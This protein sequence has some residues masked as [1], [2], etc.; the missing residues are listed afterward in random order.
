MA[1]C[2]KCNA[3]IPD[4]RI[5]CNK[6]MKEIETPYDEDYLDRLLNQGEQAGSDT[7]QQESHVRE[8]SDERLDL[9]LEANMQE[10]KAKDSNEESLDNAFDFLISGSTLE[11]NN[12]Q[13]EA[14]EAVEEG[15]KKDSEDVDDI[16]ILEQIIDN[17][18]YEEEDKEPKEFSYDSLIDEVL[19][20]DTPVVTD[21][22]SSDNEI[23]SLLDSD[24]FENLDSK[25]SAV[26]EEKEFEL[27]DEE[28][29]VATPK[30][31]SSSDI[32]IS[33]EDIDI[34]AELTSIDDE[35]FNNDFSS[36]FVS[37]ADIESLLHSLDS[38]DGE[39]ITFESGTFNDIATE[40]KKEE[41]TGDSFKDKFKRL[42]MNKGEK[43]VVKKQ[44][45]IDIEQ[46]ELKQ[47]L[48]LEKE[49]KRK[50]KEELKKA[51]D[52]E[53]EEKKAAKLQEKEA[54]KFEKANRTVEVVVD[55][56]KINKI[57]A[58]IVVVIGAIIC[59]GIIFGINWFS[60][61]NTISRAKRYYKQ[62][63]YIE[64]YSQIASMELKEDDQYLYNELRIISKLQSEYEYYESAIQVNKKEDAIFH[65]IK[66]LRK[67]NAH[68]EKAKECEVDDIYD[69]IYDNIIEAFDETFSISEK[70]ALEI[71]ELSD[72]E[73]VKVIEKYKSES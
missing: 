59:A 53:K 11:G 3:I 10:A 44:K 30:E 71:A 63:Q 62:E 34:S 54:K 72:N 27:Y 49:E 32:D 7:K 69:D 36:D 26:D 48:D 24:F 56:G 33:N 29:I 43:V 1:Q 61:S 13:Q 17:F 25:E 21:T 22:S 40:E 58:G 15:A 20:Q 35:I 18:A 52:A 55:E 37:A 68:Y 38:G 9:L 14:S 65:L 73:V 67:Y 66:G 46:E 39:E 51:K 31:S 2:K 4:N 5:Y 28:S 16:D 50:L 41:T 60:Y 64:A 42:F 57:G 23:Q 6:C 45:D 70:K 8:S 19:A 12:S 47:Q